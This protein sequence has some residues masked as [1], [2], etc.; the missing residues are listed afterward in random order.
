MGSGY[1]GSGYMGSGYTGAGYTGAGDRCGRRPLRRGTCRPVARCLDRGDEL[2]VGDAVEPERSARPDPRFPR[3]RH[4]HV[5]RRELLVARELGAV[6]DD[7]CG[8]ARVDARSHDL[9]RAV[10]A[11][12]RLDRAVH[13]L[14]STE[15]ADHG[16]ER[17]VVSLVGPTDDARQGLPLL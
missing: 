13:F 4:E 5:A 3:L 7:R 10:G 11:R 9:V 17:F 14:G 15:A 12:V 8:D 6:A 1:I 16:A 2:A